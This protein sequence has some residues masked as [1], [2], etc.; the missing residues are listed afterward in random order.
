MNTVDGQ[1]ASRID[2]T[3]TEIGLD[4]EN[5]T[6]FP[7]IY[8]DHQAIFMSLKLNNCKERGKGYWK[9]NNMLLHDRSFLEFMN[10][11]IRTIM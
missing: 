7:I 1:K 3:L 10:K 2:L 5:I 11:E 4:V 8:T 9:F 6:F